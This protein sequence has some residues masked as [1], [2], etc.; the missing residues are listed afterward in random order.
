LALFVVFRV[1]SLFVLT[2]FGVMCCN[3]YLL[4]VFLLKACGVSL[5]YSA[6]Q[7]RTKASSTSKQKD[8]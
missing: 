6:T 7:P 8:T 5:D 3:G 1:L 2:V 4:V